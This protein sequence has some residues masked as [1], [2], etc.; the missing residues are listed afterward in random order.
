MSLGERLREMLDPGTTNGSSAPAGPPR[1]RARSQAQPVIPTRSYDAGDPPRAMPRAQWLGLGLA[2]ALAVALT[3]GL[4]FASLTITRPSTQ[5]A[6]PTPLPVAASPITAAPAPPFLV[7]PTV[8]LPAPGAGELPPPTPPQAAGQRLQIANTG[9]DGAN[10]RRD[11]GQNGEKIVTIPEGSL[12]EI[13]GPDRTVEG[14]VWRN[15]RDLQGDTGWV[16][17]G[18]L[19]P[20]GTAPIVSAPAPGTTSNATVVPGTSATSGTS[21]TSGTPVARPTS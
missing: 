15:I 20:E 2:A 10:L 6:T 11:P 4:V 16:A 21:G 18:F 12:V 17:G 9:G 7:T 3:A 5:T 19:A 8:T 1:R 14:T 13:V